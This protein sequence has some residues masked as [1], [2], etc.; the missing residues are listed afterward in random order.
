[1][2]AGMEE[3]GEGASSEGLEQVVVDALVVLIRRLRLPLGHLP[4]AFDL[5]LFLRVPLDLDF[6][7]CLGWPS[8]RA[9]TFALAALALEDEEEYMVDLLLVVVDKGAGYRPSCDSDVVV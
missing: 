8:T 6:L 3:G 7:K 4:L 5:V 2:G 1:M 9:F